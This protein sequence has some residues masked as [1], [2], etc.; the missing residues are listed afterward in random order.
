MQGLY[1]ENRRPK[2]KAELKRFLAD[3]GSPA[4]IRV[5][6]TSMFGNEYDGPLSEMPTGTSVTFVG[7]DPYTK[8]SFYGQI[9]WSEKKGWVIS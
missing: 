8:R 9:K 5:Q 4:M 1:L 7:P 3:G 6:A 2:S